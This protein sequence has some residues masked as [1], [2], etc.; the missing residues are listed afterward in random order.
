RRGEAHLAG[1]HLLDEASGD[2]N[3]PYL[4]RQLAGATCGW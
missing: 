3:L 2:Y 4:A 1:S